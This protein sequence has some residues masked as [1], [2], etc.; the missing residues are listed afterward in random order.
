MRFHPAPPWCA[1]VLLP[2]A[3]ACAGAPH[4]SDGAGPAAASGDATAA[5]EKAEDLER[6]VQLAR[7]RLEK[8]RLELANQ[9]LAS[10]DAIRHAEADA[11]L[12]RLSLSN[13][14]ERESKLKLDKARLELQRAEDSLDESKEEL[15]QLEMMYQEHDIADRTK[16]IVLRRGKRRVERSEAALALERREM[17]QLER[18]VLPIERQKL[19]LEVDTKERA[20]AA[21]RRAA[22]EAALE[23]EIAIAGATAELRKLEKELQKVS[24]HPS[25]QAGASAAGGSPTAPHDIQRPTAAP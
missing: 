9:S 5:A 22:T 25:K 21:A 15:A 4:A 16:E 7:M 1:L 2:L 3:A 11:E 10:Q 12:A 20:L 24:E 17:D 23:R 13:F 19:V 14:E 18:Q 8:A 6:Q